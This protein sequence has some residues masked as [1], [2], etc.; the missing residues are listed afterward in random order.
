[1]T[2]ADEHGPTGGPIEEKDPGEQVLASASH[3]FMWPKISS[4][5][6]NSFGPSESF[7]IH[8]VPKQ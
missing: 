5:R 2:F 6:A 1:M 8:P 3:R 7:S 4:P